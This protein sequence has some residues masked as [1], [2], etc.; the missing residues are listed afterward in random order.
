MSESRD[1]VEPPVSATDGNAAASE[2]NAASPTENA[3]AA[4]IVSVN[5]G[6][7]GGSKAAKTLFILLCSALLIGLL[8]WLGQNYLNAWKQSAKGGKKEIGAE[9]DPMNPEAT[10]APVTKVGAASGKAPPLQ[11]ASPAAAPGANENDGVR[12]IRGADGKVMTDPQGR[13]LG[14]DTTGKVVPVPAIAPL[15]GPAAATMAGPQTPVGPPPPSRYSGALFVEQSILRAAAANASTASTPAANL[16]PGNAAG[17]TTTVTT[18]QQGLEMLRALLP[19][20]QR[21]AGGGAVP[22]AA[23]GQSAGS[24]PAVAPYGGPGAD[25]F[26]TGNSSVPGTGGPTSAAP[27]VTTVANTQVATRTPVVQARLFPDQNLMIPKGRQA[28]CVLTT[29]IDDQLPGYASCVLA[30]DL[31]SDNGKTLLLEHGSEVWGEYGTLSQPGLTRIAVN[32]VRI[33]TRDGI[34][35]DLSSPGTDALGGS[36]LPGHYNPRWGERIGAA[37]LLSLVKDVTTAIINSQTKSGG[38]TVSVAP[39]GQNT[40]GGAGNLSDQVIRETLRVRP[41]VT[42]AEGTRIS[43]Y[44]ARDLDFRSV[45]ELRHAAKIARATSAVTP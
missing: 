9:V 5:N 25:A 1:G 17:G 32:W 40:V 37:V 43:I 35:V 33:K 10:R 38:T 30:E 15:P 29:R 8:A 12:A 4:E 28:G 44:V 14:V 41:N 3:P 42:I 13:A 7:V 39:P 11:A 21:A 16:A 45:Y 23:A 18:Q 6:N 20:A 36:G 19:G 2:L 26:P 24:L 31:F 34:T 22:A 27:T